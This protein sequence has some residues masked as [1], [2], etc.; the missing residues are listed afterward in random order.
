MKR[1]KLEDYKNAF[2][3][4]GLP[5]FN[6]AEPSAPEKTKIT[7]SVSVTLWDQWDLRMGDITLGTFC[8]HFKVL[9]FL[10]HLL[11]Y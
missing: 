1:M 2:M 11:M 4:L 7:D 9:I 3:N 6:L 10:S 8:E 5:L